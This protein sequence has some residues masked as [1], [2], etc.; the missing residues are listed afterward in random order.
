MG[1]K[2]HLRQRSA[3]NLADLLRRFGC[4]EGFVPT[5]RMGSLWSNTVWLSM[6]TIEGGFSPLD[7]THAR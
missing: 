6:F 2:I 3:S 1:C 5:E 4:S 7:P